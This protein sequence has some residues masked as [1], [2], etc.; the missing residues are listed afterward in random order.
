MT[1]GEFHSIEINS[2]ILNRDERQRQQLKEEQLEELADSIGSVGLIHPIVVTRE[3]VLVS[4]E[5]RTRGLP[6][7]WL[8]AHQRSVHRRT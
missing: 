6:S 7:P 1:S 3:R 4:G 2:I 5:R 8:D